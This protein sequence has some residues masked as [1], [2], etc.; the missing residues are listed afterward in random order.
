VLCKKQQ[1]FLFGNDRFLL[2]KG[3]ESISYA[4]EFPQHQRLPFTHPA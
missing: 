3:V 4:R 2:L 1:T